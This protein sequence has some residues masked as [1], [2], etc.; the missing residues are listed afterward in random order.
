MTSHFLARRALVA[1]LAGLTLTAPPAL[2]GSDNSRPVGLSAEEQ[3]VLA[4]RGVGAPTPPVE[5]KRE[6]PRAQIADAGFDWGAAGLGAGAGGG[7]ILL[8][9]GLALARRPRIRVVR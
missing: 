1:S 2:A 3:Q 6:A 5:V 7:L 4:S 8:A 9:A